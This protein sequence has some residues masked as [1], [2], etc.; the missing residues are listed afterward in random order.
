MS[1]C[2]LS[3]TWRFCTGDKQQSGEYTHWVLYGDSSHA[4]DAR[5]AQHRFGHRQAS[6]WEADNVQIAPFS[7]EDIM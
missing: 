4:Q 7:V 5:F 6:V 2:F 1:A 3:T